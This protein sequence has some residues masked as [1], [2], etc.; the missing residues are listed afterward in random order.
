MP[1]TPDQIKKALRDRGWNM[2]K[3]GRRV[4]PKVTPTQVRRVVEG[5]DAS[6]RIRSAIARIL[7]RTVDS[8]WTN[9]GSSAAA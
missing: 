5:D 6:P 4:R 9:S 2:S 7:E 3:V 8:I 1:M